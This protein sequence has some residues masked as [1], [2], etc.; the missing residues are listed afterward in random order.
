M[1]PFNLNFVTMRFVTE[2]CK[3]LS[4]I[5]EKRRLKNLVLLTIVETFYE[6]ILQMSDYI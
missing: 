3:S 2:Y 5:I 4:C 6:T 1:K